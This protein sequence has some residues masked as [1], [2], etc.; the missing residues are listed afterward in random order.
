MSRANATQ[1]RA[2]LAYGPGHSAFDITPA[3]ATQLQ[4]NSEDVT[5]RAIF[6]GG[7]GNVTGKVFTESGAAATV[8]FAGVA[9]GT[10]L[11]IAFIEVHS[12]GTTATSIVGL[13]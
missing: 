4:Q 2:Q 13:L 12:T 3:D 6:V 5:V 10:V 7:A 11:N 8:T 1:A 9:A